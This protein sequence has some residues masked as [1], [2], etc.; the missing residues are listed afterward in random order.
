MQK[1]KIKRIVII[2]AAVLAVIA[3]VIIAVLFNKSKTN[4]SFK[5]ADVMQIYIGNSKEKVVSILGE[6]DKCSEDESQYYYF[7]KSDV[8][9]DFGGKYIEIAFDGNS[10]TEIYYDTRYGAT[11]ETNKSLI[12]YRVEKS[13]LVLGETHCDIEFY[14]RFSDG[15]FYRG[16]AVADCVAING[17]ANNI[18]AKIEWRDKW[19]YQYLSDTL[20]RGADD[21]HFGTECYIKD[22]T[23][24]ITGNNFK[25]SDEMTDLRRCDYRQIKNI[26]VRE[27]VTELDFRS[28]KT[29]F[30]RWTGLERIDYQGDIQ[31]WYM[32]DFGVN[33][34]EFAHNLFIAGL[35]VG[36]VTIVSGSWVSNRAFAYCENL[37]AVTVAD[38]VTEIGV[39]AFR[40]C[41]N[42]C[43]VT[44]PET[45]SEIGLNA[46]SECDSVK[47]A[48]LPCSV[49]SCFDIGSFTDV[50]IFGEHIPSSAFEGCSLLE[51]VS[52]GDS[53]SSIDNRAFWGCV[54]L[55]SL[56]IGN[57]VTSVGDYAFGNCKSLTDIE[58]PASVIEM[59][60]GVF[61]G[62]NSI[63]CIKIPFVGAL[64]S[65]CIGV[66]DLSHIFGSAEQP[67]E[68][69]I[70]RS[71]HTVIL[72]GDILL[73]NAFNGCKF[74]RE[75]R[76]DGHI[77]E[78]PS[79]AF[80]GCER[81]S[82]LK[83]PDSVTAVERAFD[84]CNSLFT[85]TLPQSV[86]YVAPD[87][88]A[89]AIRLFEIINLS[90]RVINTE[91]TSVKNVCTDPSDSKIII[92]DGF[93]FY[94]GDDGYCLIGFESPSGRLCLPE[95]FNGQ[96]YEIFGQVFLGLTDAT[97]V[98]LPN[99][100]TEINSEWFAGNEFLQS[101]MLPDTISEIPYGA[102]MGCEFLKTVTLL[103][104][105]K[106]FEQDTFSY[107]A[108]LETIILP[109][110]LEFVGY[111]AFTGC[112]SLKSVYYKGSPEDWE[113]IVIAPAEFAKDNSPL[114][115]ARKYFYS[116]TEP[117]DASHNYWH[118]N[119]RGEIEAWN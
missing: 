97:D 47:T 59:G 46:F 100:I 116:D 87:A 62:C 48:V 73:E 83:I 104:T 110:S 4:P 63:E 93:I 7:E 13:D 77:T 107:C 10:V 27:N 94:D 18:R 58:I 74:I 41:K 52:V 42:L 117:I 118:Y 12:T 56:S 96:K 81:L 40:G 68:S 88:F 14:S 31:D 2:C 80:Y 26:V 45:I 75:I 51:N 36:E 21:A 79:N 115:D 44:L 16:K 95:T 99:G 114:I 90:G 71:L 50:S 69:P 32:I 28:S 66:T 15:S 39:E 22:Q 103:G 105:I 53:V 112:A 72:T 20:V 35:P 43:S 85:L 65:D 6:P 25:L 119:E 64:A 49:L 70:P 24:V 34:L 57:G 55:Q 5:L 1:S 108:A 102:F 29:D 92:N 54:N 76:F 91:N 33:P 84:G 37:T 61:E 109:R 17:T 106:R 38:G 113:N 101:V 82:N 30:R 60:F 23:L 78:I 9:D 3:I 86:K 19:G 8:N 11:G 98:I 111:G 67:M 89:G